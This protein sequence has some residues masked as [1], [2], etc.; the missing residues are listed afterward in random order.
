MQLSNVEA[1]AIAM[2]PQEALSG[3]SL[4]IKA[5]VAMLQ[6]QHTKCCLYCTTRRHLST[7]I[8]STSSMTQKDPIVITFRTE[9]EDRRNRLAKNNSAASRRC[10]NNERQDAAASRLLEAARERG[11]DS[12]WPPT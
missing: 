11:E 7:F 4:E 1:G 10:S 8:S 6:P 12:K 2:A 3:S 9:R 5:G